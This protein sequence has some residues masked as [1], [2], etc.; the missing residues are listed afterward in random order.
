MNDYKV[1]SDR[2]HSMVIDSGWKEVAETVLAWLTDKGLAPTTETVE[3]ARTPVSRETAQ[4]A[5]VPAA[6]A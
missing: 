1:F 5:A 2:G 3:T 4:S 6:R